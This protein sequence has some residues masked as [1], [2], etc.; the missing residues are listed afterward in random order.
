MRTDVSTTDRIGNGSVAGFI[1][2]LVLSALHEPVTLVTESVG[3]R[4]P[5]AGLLFHFFVGTLLWGGAFGS[6]L[7]ITSAMSATLAEDE[8][9]FS[10]FRM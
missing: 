6:V 3:A 1:A 7:A 4:T 8:N 10:P 9:H 2:T 5:I